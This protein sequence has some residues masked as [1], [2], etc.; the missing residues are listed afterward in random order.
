M[1]QLAVYLKKLMSTQRNSSIL[2]VDEEVGESTGRLD[3]L[4]FIG[5][6]LVIGLGLVLNSALLLTY[7][8]RRILYYPDNQ[9][10]SHPRACASW[11]AMVCATNNDRSLHYDQQ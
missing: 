8:L 9:V 3:H 4:F 5:L 1:D 10:Q 7:V 6:N 11:S 2:M